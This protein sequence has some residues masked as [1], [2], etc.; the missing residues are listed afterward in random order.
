[1][2]DLNAARATYRNIRAKANSIYGVSFREFNANCRVEIVN[3]G[4]DLAAPCDW[5]QAA[6]VTLDWLHADDLADRHEAG[7]WL[8]EGLAA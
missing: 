8:N 6:R 5:I 3:E 1:M 4:G 7:G 2:T